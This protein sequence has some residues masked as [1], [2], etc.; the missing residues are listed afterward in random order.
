MSP[1]ETTSCVASLVLMPHKTTDSRSSVSSASTEV[2]TREKSPVA[3]S[4]PSETKAKEVPIEIFLDKQTHTCPQHQ[5][6]NSADDGKSSCSRPPATN[7]RDLFL[8]FDKGYNLDQAFKLDNL[9]ESP[10]PI[11]LSSSHASAAQKSTCLVQDGDR[12]IFLVEDNR[13][14]KASSLCQGSGARNA[15]PSDEVSENPEQNEEGEDTEFSDGESEASLEDVRQHHG[16]IKTQK[17][18]DPDYLTLFEAHQRRLED[19]GSQAPGQG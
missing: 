11:V 4:S 10:V 2:G 8:S 15:K 17:Q 12:Y 7:I 19:V 18:D 13:S 9:F 1:E 16:I 14:S 3:L 6:I 5:G